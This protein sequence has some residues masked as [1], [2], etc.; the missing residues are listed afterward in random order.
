MALNA[1]Q[2][3]GSAVMKLSVEAD[4]ARAEL[5][6]FEDDAGKAGGASASKFSKGMDGVRAGVDKAFLPALGVLAGLGAAGMG[7]ASAAEQAEQSQARLANV[8][9]QM[10]FAQYQSSV[11]AQAASLMAK[12]AVDDDEIK[13]VQTKIATF[14]ELTKT[15]G[16]MGGMF[17]RV[18]QA[19]F[20]MASAGFGDAS[21]NAV[22]LGK[23]LQD[24]VKGITALAK[25]GVTFSEAEKNMIKS[26]VEAGDMAGAQ[27]MVM[28]AVEKQVGGTAEATKTGSQEMSVAF[29]EMQESIGAVLLP[30][31][32][33]LTDIA[34]KFANWAQENPTLVTVLAG[35]LGVLAGAIVALKIAMSIATVVSWAMNASF[36][37]NPITW[38]ILAIVALVA[39]VVLMYNKV[40]WFRAFIDTAWD[41]IQTAFGWIIDAAQGFWDILTGLFNWVKDNWKT[42]LFVALTGPIGLAVK[43]I[44]ENWD[45]VVQFFKGIGPKIGEAMKTLVNIL[46]WPWRTAANVIIDLVNTIIGAWNSIEFTLPSQNVFGQEIGGWTIGTPDLG[47]IPKIPELY[48]GGRAMFGGTALVGEKGPELLKMPAGASV[49]PLSSR[50][51]GGGDFHLHVTFPSDFTGNK[52]QLKSWMEQITDEQYRREV[53][54]QFMEGASN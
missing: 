37:A 27:E 50:S 1:E 34:M 41:S 19:T 15:A 8:M 46:T 16:T 43:W 36:L 14:S 29:G 22:Q 3:I 26:M 6:K 24:P 35:A 5:K 45:K 12:I 52:T 25:S 20:D 44:V 39:A 17:D 54:R 11:D 33:A 10:G 38:I 18:T 53:T 30:A 51:S 9:N 23:A 7:A 48:K 21:S 2:V 49:I 31:F 47:M 40:D 32:K 42:V 13:A 4:K 28:A